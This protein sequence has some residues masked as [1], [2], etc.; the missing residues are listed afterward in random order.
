MET[1]KINLI[2][3]V[4]FIDDYNFS[5]ISSYD[6][7]SQGVYNYFSNNFFEYI[8]K[9][10]YFLFG[11]ADLNDILYKDDPSILTFNLNNVRTTNVSMT[12]QTIYFDI[13]SNYDVSL[14]DLFKGKLLYPVI[15]IEKSR[16]KPG[17]DITI[18]VKVEDLSITRRRKIEKIINK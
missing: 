9:Q 7:Y 4:T 15:V 17:K 10:I 14:K 13:S 5:I 8:N 11:G 18:V 2:E 6:T 16:Y 1:I 12:H 3:K